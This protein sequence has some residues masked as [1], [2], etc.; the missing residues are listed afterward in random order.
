[1]PSTTQRTPATSLLFVTASLMLALSCRSVDSSKTAS[2]SLPQ[3]PIG[4]DAGAARSS[5]Q[6]GLGSV[7][8]ATVTPHPVAMELCDALHVLPA[9]R[10]AACCGNK[11]QS[12]LV[13]QCVRVVSAS[14]QSRSVEVDGASV[15]AC[16]AEME[17]SLAGCDW[18]TPSLPLAPPACQRLLRGQLAAGAVCR[19][20]LECAGDL[21]CDGL[22]AT[23]TGICSPPA[24]LGQGCGSHVDVL[25][26]YA[27]QRDLETAH[28]FCADHC[29]LAIHKCEP[30][31]EVVALP[32]AG[33]GCARTGCG[34]GLRCREGVCAR[35]AQPGEM[36]ATDLDCAA[37]GCA[38]GTDGQKMC[39][40]KCTPS[41]DALDARTAG[42][43]M[44]LPAR[45]G[46]DVARR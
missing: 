34:A 28:P 24:R 9:A 13:D 43:G 1:M 15:A 11:P 45:S 41:F 14:L 16:R 31:P 22:G 18:V 27:L 33:E 44:H 6:D 36:C 42:A 46:S 30:V 37:G 19:S 21:H 5:A 10:M 38:R 26:T 3:E 12:S 23:K 7:Y 4:G 20:S 39:G 25:A 2:T 29:S 35:L 40:T 32:R 8:P 17:K